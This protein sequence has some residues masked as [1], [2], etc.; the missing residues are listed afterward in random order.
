MARYLFEATYSTEGLKGLIAA[1]AKSRLQAVDD[2]AASVGG[3]IVSF[4][5]AN[6]GGDVYLI[7]DLP[8]DEAAAGITL[9]VGASGALDS[10]KLTK[11]FS[12]EQIEAAA[13]R[14]ATYVPPGG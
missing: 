9:R 7:C 12:A 3:S 1:G 13:S 4:D 5:F 8:D 10:F 6:G 14:N 2:L 11:L